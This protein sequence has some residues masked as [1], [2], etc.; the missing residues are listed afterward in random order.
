MH[1]D[2]PETP[3]TPTLDYAEE[4]ALGYHNR[5]ERFFVARNPG[6]YD[7]R[8]RYQNV[9][10]PWHR[11][12]AVEVLND[13]LKQSDADANEA[14]DAAAERDGS[15]VVDG[16]DK[17]ADRDDASSAPAS[18]SHGELTKKAVHQ[19]SSSMRTPGLFQN[20]FV[21]LAKKT[22]AQQNNSVT[23][24]S[25]QPARVNPGLLKRFVTT[26]LTKRVMP[27]VVA[28][29]THAQNMTS[30]LQRG[31]IVP[32]RD[33]VSVV[34]GSAYGVGIYTATQLSTP[35][36]YARGYVNEPQVLICGLIDNAVKPETIVAPLLP[37]PSP[38]LATASSEA[39]IPSHPV[40][41]H[42]VRKAQRQAAAVAKRN[43]S[44]RG[45]KARNSSK[46][47]IT[48]ALSA[49]STPRLASN[50]SIKR[51]SSY[52]IINDERLVLPLAVATIDG[53]HN[54]WSNTRPRT[55]TKP[56]DYAQHLDSCVQQARAANV[57]PSNI[58][59]ESLLSVPWGRMAV[60]AIRHTRSR[61]SPLV[62]F[63]VVLRL[64]FAIVGVV[65]RAGAGLVRA[66]R[67]DWAQTAPVPAS[68]VLDDAAIKLGY[69][70]LVIATGSRYADLM[71][72]SE[73]VLPCSRVDRV[74]A[75]ARAIVAGRV[76]RA[77]VIGGGIVG[78]E[79]A[80]E[81][82]EAYP[83]FEV[84]LAHSGDQLMSSSP[85]VPRAA[86][87]YAERSLSLSGVRLA[88]GHRIT[89]LPQ[90]AP[91]APHPLRLGA[92]G[93]DIEYESDMVFV[94]TGL[95]PNTGFLS[96][97]AAPGNAAPLAHA[98]DAKGFVTVTPALN[99]DSAPHV[100]ALGDV[101]AL[102]G[103]KLA[104]CAELMADVVSANI[105]RL[106]RGLGGESLRSYTSSPVPMII[107]LGAYDGFA[108]HR[109]WVA[110]GLLP[111][112]CKLAVE[113]LSLA[114]YAHSSNTWLF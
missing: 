2:Q 23:I 94:A 48:F 62:C 84:T 21:Q 36:A 47:G 22:F 35:A 51:V 83:D 91:G 60:S 65:G 97:P 81:L 61:H 100:F 38:S 56:L 9:A 74:A 18:E 45:A 13:P 77:M 114:M 111:A 107:S 30:I 28:H 86:A 34:N 52:R 42:V 75:A 59:P 4:L 101:A 99:L 16:D 26:A 44:H 19:V 57:P 108:V 11:R 98:L 1:Y 102:P 49:S 50:G 112:M 90:A 33:G 73:R 7:Y 27:S 109:G 88:L 69:D 29:G 24:R 46:G 20:E 41:G 10:H 64:F 54:R 92:A 68:A 93:T 14:E 37:P 104:Q 110:Y 15:D 82:A 32:G 43:R 40:R 85:S 105:S 39:S 31:L 53:R 58:H 113:T 87:E 6:Y 71:P 3:T 103:E 63:S 12:L 17:G 67:A 78:V 89:A 106:E 95:L 70:Y 96:Q 80:A 55:S 66:G 8:Y 72:L 76:T 79:L 5:K 25:I